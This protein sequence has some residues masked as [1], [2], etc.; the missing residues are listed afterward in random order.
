MPLSDLTA[1]QFRPQHEEHNKLVGGRLP[2]NFDS[3]L[4]P[5]RMELSA[6]LM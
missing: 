1:V 2:V 4:T 3:M 5:G 6:L